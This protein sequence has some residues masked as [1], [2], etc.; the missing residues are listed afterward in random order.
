MLIIK[1]YGCNRVFYQLILSN[2]CNL[3]CRYCLG[4]AF[5]NVERGCW[6]EHFELEENM[7]LKA[8]YSPEE[9][10]SFISSDP[11]PVITFYGGEPLLAMEKIKAIM[12]K[13]KAKWF[14]M[15]TNGLLLDQL[16][17][18][19]V[20]RMHTI[21]VSLDGDERTTDHYRGKGVYRKVMD[22]V[23]L[24]KENGFQG[25]LIARMTVAE[26]TDI[27]QA[28]T[29]LLENEDHSFSS[30]HWQLDMEF[31]HDFEKR[32]FVRWANESYN[33]GI[34]RLVDFWLKEME[35]RGK[36]FKL[37]PF[38]GVMQ[39]L[40]KNEKALLRCGSGH[41]DY[42]VQTDGRIIVCPIMAGVKNNYVGHIKTSKPSEL[43]KVFVG[44]PCTGCDIYGLCGGRCYYAF[45]AKHWGENKKHACAVTR[46]FIKALQ[47]VKPR[48]EKLI[49]GGKLSLKDFEF[50]KYNGAEIIP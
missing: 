6:P 49:G 48:V 3:Q 22:N 16:P 24:V 23:K 18:D 8:D 2:E 47:E 5:E 50:V 15:Q 34:T 39:S 9:L 44:E 31:D 45:M 25:E 12:D 32:D 7:P 26:E 42:S 1:I 46:H 36:V 30:V 41:E 4:K 43:P 37:Y 14:M 10:Q 19:Y 33:P 29:H 20:N 27:F 17:S 21:L 35:E 40:L 13:V 38:L 28:V 11:E